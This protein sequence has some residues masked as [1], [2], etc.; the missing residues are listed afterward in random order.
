MRKGGLF[1]TSPSVY[2][3]HSDVGREAKRDFSFKKQLRQMWSEDPLWRITS[4]SILLSW[5]WAYHTDFMSENTTDASFSILYNPLT[6]QSSLSI[7]S[8]VKKKALYSFIQVNTF[9]LS[10]ELNEYPVCDCTS[11][12]GGNKFREL[13]FISNMKKLSKNAILFTF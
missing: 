11:C 10:I 5:R 8:T 13:T 3:L 2:I 12:K 6:A 4:P 7:K 1:S 9:S